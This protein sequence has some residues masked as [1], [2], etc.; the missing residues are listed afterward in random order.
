MFLHEG[1]VK[2]IVRHPHL[3]QYSFEGLE[4]HRASSPPSA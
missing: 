3:L 4:E 1:V 2:M